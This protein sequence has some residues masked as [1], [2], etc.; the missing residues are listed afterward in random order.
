MV[1][2]FHLSD[3][4]SCDFNIRLL[5]LSAKQIIFHNSSHC[6][7]LSMM[8]FD[9]THPKVAFVLIYL[10][11][12]EIL[13]K[14]SLELGFEDFVWINL[15]SCNYLLLF[16][17]E[18]FVSSRGILILSLLWIRYIR[19]LVLVSNS[20]KFFGGILYILIDLLILII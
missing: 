13:A 3:T 19:I 4:L 11:F 7:D 9:K 17:Q 8:N 5:F 16:M 14:D 20:R 15:L 10:N 1:Y 18:F 12:V 2:L 6:P